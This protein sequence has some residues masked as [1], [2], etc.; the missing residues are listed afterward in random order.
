[1]GDCVKNVWQKAAGR[2]RDSLGEMSYET[3]IRP[4]NFVEMLGHTAVTAGGDP[5][6]RRLS[7]ASMPESRDPPGD[8][9]TQKCEP[10]PVRG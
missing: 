8:E 7:P 6:E 5:P 10:R 9:P 3:W 4:L 2:I 1:M